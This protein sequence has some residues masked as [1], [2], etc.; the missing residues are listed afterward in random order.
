M[1]VREFQKEHFFCQYFVLYENG[2]FFCTN[3]KDQKSRSAGVWH[4]C[5]YRKS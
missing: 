1:E 2:L 3:K 5:R 4:N